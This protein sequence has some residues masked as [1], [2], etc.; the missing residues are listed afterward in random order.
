MN[1]KQQRKKIMF[2]LIHVREEKIKENAGKRIL[3]TQNTGKYF[4]FFFR[5]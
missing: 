2:I 3:Q 4:F 1:K 5:G